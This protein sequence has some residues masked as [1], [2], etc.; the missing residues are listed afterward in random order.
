[1]PIVFVLDCRSPRGD[2]IQTRLTDEG[3]HTLAMHDA[4]EAMQ[5]LHCV[6]ADLL[7][8]DVHAVKP[9]A[10]RFLTSLRSNP[11]YCQLPI[12]FVGAGLAECRQLKPSVR[13]GGIMMEGQ[14]LDDVMLNVRSYVAPLSEPYH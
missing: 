10:Q 5:T 8:V 9:D 1:M 4:D 14:T 2:S 3:Y 12:L 11:T 13:P 6:R 7:V